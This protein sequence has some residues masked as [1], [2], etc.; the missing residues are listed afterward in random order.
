MIHVVI[1]RQVAEGMVST[2]EQLLRTALQRSFVAHGFVS[3]EAFQD[4]NDPH[5][6]ILICKWRSEQDWQRW[7][8]SED[9]MELMNAMR[10]ILATEEKVILLTN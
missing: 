4:L 1:E 7:S 8:H 10:P 6:R 3:G 2:Y 5:R 9:R